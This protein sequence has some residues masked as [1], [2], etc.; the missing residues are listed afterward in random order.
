MSNSKM[1]L[2]YAVA[3]YKLK[4]H[5]S[6]VN[7]KSRRHT[8]LHYLLLLCDRRLKSFEAPTNHRC[9]I[10]KMRLFCPIV[11]CYWLFYICLVVT[12]YKPYSR[13]VLME[14]SIKTSAPPS[15]DNEYPQEPQI[16]IL[17]CLWNN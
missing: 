12:N 4:K 10:M 2:Y 17:L 3:K 7:H 16:D 5:D 1:H 14:N 13:E 6:S 9:H 8:V 15:A 11:E